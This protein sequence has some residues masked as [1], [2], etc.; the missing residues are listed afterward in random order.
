MRERDTVET[1]DRILFAAE[2]LFSEVGFDKA[3]VDDIAKE[4]GVNKALI[5]YYFKS[6]DEILQTL[7]S[8]LVEDARRMLVK[9]MEGTPD[10]INGDNFK[11]LFDVYIKFVMERRKII[12]VAIAESTKES[13]ELSVIMELGNLIINA[14]INRI[15]EAYETKGLNFPEDKTEL[16]VMEFFTGLMPIISF[17]VYKDQWESYYNMSEEKLCA[18]FYQVFKRTHLAA[19]LRH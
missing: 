12:R 4:A 15:R 2:K 16:L 6:K 14:E 8:K 7:F 3:R 5:Y 9:C 17:A 11:A 1:K 13:S 18:K 19:H 10:I